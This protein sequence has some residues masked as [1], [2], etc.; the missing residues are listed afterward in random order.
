MPQT[1]R[2][3]RYGRRKKQEDNNATSRRRRGSPAQQNWLAAKLQT[4][5]N[6]VTELSH[7]KLSFR[8]LQDDKVVPC[9][10]G[11]ASNKLGTGQ[12]SLDS[13][14]CERLRTK[15]ANKRVRQVSTCIIGQIVSAKKRGDVSRNCRERGKNTSCTDV[16]VCRHGEHSKIFASLEFQTEQV[17]QVKNALPDAIIQQPSEKRACPLNRR[18]IV[19][20]RLNLVHE[21]R[22]RMTEEMSP[23]A[24]PF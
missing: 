20:F 7:F 8:R 24:P 1:E 14:Y 3:C 15:H 17:Q 10:K 22:E 12:V 21:S 23:T 11:M 9:V 16:E 5:G 4:R 19:H 2:H 13:T 18:R 6:T